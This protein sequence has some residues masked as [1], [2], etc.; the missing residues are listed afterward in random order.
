MYGKWIRDLCTQMP[1]LQMEEQA[2]MSDYTSF[3]IGGPAECM[4]FPASE[5]EMA[6]LL[7]F[8]CEREI[9]WLLLG[10]GSNV[11][12]PDEGLDGMVIQTKKA[13][14]D[15]YTA[16]DDPDSL[17]ALCGVTLSRLSVF[18]AQ[19]GLSGLEFAQGIPGTV[20]GGVV[21]NA[22]AYGGEIKDCAVQTWTL[23]A[24]GSQF[25]YFGE[26]QGFRYRGSAISDDGNSVYSV[27]FR[28]R[29]GDPEQILE[30]M[31]DFAA[32][33]RE[34]QP[35]DL[36]SAGSTFKRPEGGYA[37]ALIDRAGLK[38]LTV[39]GAAVSEKHAGFVVNLGGATAD[40]V[41]RLIGLIQERVLETSG[42]SLE[43]E[44]R[45]LRGREKA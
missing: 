29:R 6:A 20:G 13:M 36:P 8:A 41:K 18:A 9:P 35:L 22:G 10:A 15:L 40:D 12:A 2:P 34:K 16:A 1:K 45:I 44:V 7:R 42:I 33:R 26:E 23:T 11:L 14:Q 31:Q 4:V 30:T 24:Q 39:G 38:G 25:S 43:P 27:R 21:M 3:R 37:A 5:E 17:V 32:R 28:L 19:R